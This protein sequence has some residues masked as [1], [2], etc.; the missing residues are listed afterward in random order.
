M[1]GKINQANGL[2]AIAGH[3]HA[4]RRIFA[5]RI[6]KI[7]LAFFGHF[8]H[9]FAGH[10]LAERGDTDQGIFLRPH[11]VARTRFAKAGENA[12]VAVD[13]DQRHPYRAAAIKDMFGVAINDLRRQQRI[14]RD[15]R[16]LRH[17]F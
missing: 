14:G 10:Q 9:H 2:P 3:R 17:A 11:V 7:N 8:Y 6:V 13:S 16:D 4:W 12:L 15:G 5:Q 1:G